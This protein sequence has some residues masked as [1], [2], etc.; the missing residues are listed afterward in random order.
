MRQKLEESL[1]SIDEQIKQQAALVERVALIKADREKY[2]QE[3]ADIEA[4]DYAE[5]TGKIVARLG[6]L[7]TRMQL[8]PVMLERTEQQLRDIDAEFPESIK[9]CSR[10][11]QP[12][13]EKFADAKAAEMCAALTALGTSEREAQE[14]VAQSRHITGLRSLYYRGQYS[15]QMNNFKDGLRAL[16][17]LRPIA[18]EALKETP[19]FDQFKTV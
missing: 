8:I 5:I 12:I 17:E 3:T 2:E 4:M 13:V 15:T 6:I 10:M 1:N 9:H 14:T 11:V 18:E 19:D 7:K 16:R